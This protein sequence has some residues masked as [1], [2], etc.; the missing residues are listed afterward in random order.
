MPATAENSFTPTKASQSIAIFGKLG[1]GSGST[2]AARVAAAV[3]VVAEAVVARLRLLSETQGPAAPPEVVRAAESRRR[4]GGVTTGGRRHDRRLRDD[5][6]RDGR[7]RLLGLGLGV[8][9]LRLPPAAGVA[10][11]R[12]ASAAPP[13]GARLLVRA[14]PCACE[15]AGREE[16]RSGPVSRAETSRRSLSCAGTRVAGAW[17]R[18][19]LLRSLQGCHRM[20]GRGESDSHAPA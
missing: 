8:G 1:G 20:A 9:W 5:W 11:V 6:F 18:Y 12:S 14:S 7:L 10:A 4:G 13:A 15:G 16:C 17:D 2:A 19:R 3:A